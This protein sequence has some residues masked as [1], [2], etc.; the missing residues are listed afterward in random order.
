MTDPSVTPAVLEPP[1]NPKGGK[2]LIVDA[3][4][5]ACFSRPSLALKTAGPDDQIFIRPG[6]YEDTLFIAGRPVRLIGAGKDH[7]TIFCRRRGPFYLQQVPEGLISGVTFR[8]VG[9]DQHSAMNVLDSSCTITGCRVTDGVLSGIV[10]Y[11][12]ESRTTFVENEVCCNR[13]TG[14]FIFARARPYVARNLCRDNHHFGIAVRD[15]ESCPDLVRNVCRG[16]ML[17]GI[18]LFQYAE[19]LVAENDCHDNHDWGLVITPD[20]STTPP[21]A[22]LTTVNR[23]DKNPRGAVHV[24]DQPLGPIGR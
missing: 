23:L 13:E 18:L 24:T 6:I 2:T 12:P 1:P 9:S 3:S 15:D 22:E 21:V 8:Y 11:G 16:N 20:C 10:I 5:E 4:D 7:V 14:V 17:S 19:A